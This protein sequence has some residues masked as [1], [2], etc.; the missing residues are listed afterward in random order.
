M[1]ELDGVAVPVEGR[2][3]AVL[4]AVDA[5]VEPGKTDSAK[6]GRQCSTAE[7]GRVVAAGGLR[8]AAVPGSSDVESVPGGVHSVV[9]DWVFAVVVP[10]GV[11]VAVERGR[12]G[13]PGDVGVAAVPDSV[14]EIVVPGCVFAAVVPGGEGVAVERGRVS[15]AALPGGVGVA[16]VPGSVRAV[17]VLGRVF[18]AVVP[19][20]L[21]VAVERG[22]VGSAALP[23]GVG[24]AAVPGSVRAVVVLC[25]E[26][27]AAVSGGVGG[28]EV[29]PGCGV[30]A[31][32]SV[33][34]E[35]SA[36]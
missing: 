3:V 26:G 19:G 8:K 13:L 16:A 9:P 36:R 25:R 32:V 5:V 6:S 34:G 27:L 24:V 14:R 15:S 33:R 10:R 20:G 1:A 23:V 11:G 7:Y 4:G 2:D 12:E 22:R 31:I 21:G 30:P 29:V 18:A 17:V 28:A 35:A